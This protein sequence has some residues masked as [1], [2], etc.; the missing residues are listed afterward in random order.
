MVTVA[1][2]TCESMNFSSPCIR[3]DFLAHPAEF[4]F[5]REQIRHI[6][7]FGFQD[8]DQALFH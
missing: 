5:D 4:L 8:F 1:N 7:A 6:L 3:F 2:C